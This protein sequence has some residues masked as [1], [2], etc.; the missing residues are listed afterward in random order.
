MQD[1]REYLGR[2]CRNSLQRCLQKKVCGIESKVDIVLIGTFFLCQLETISRFSKI[3]ENLSEFLLKSLK[4]SVF[5]LLWPH[6]GCPIVN[7]WTWRTTL[8]SQWRKEK[9]S[10]SCSLRTSSSCFQ[11]LNFPD[12]EKIHRICTEITIKAYLFVFGP[13]EFIQ[14]IVKLRSETK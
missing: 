11:P 6:F 14:Y 7:W 3:L 13:T 4:S 1:P 9:T 5:R 8:R 12:L 10:I 2:S